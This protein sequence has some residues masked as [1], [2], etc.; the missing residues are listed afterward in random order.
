MQIS[1]VSGLR[2]GSQV[3]RFRSN[4]PDHLLLILALWS[5]IPGIHVSAKYF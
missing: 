2:S 1:Q 4:I 3:S 5:R